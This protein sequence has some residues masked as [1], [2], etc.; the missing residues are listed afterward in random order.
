[1]NE[2]IMLISAYAIVVVAFLVT[3]GFAEH[4]QK[5]MPCTAVQV[6]IKDTMGHNFVEEQ[7][8]MELVNNKFGNLKGKPLSSINISLLEKIINTNP[9]IA[10]A[11]VFSTIDG[12]INIEVKQRTPIVRIVNQKVITQQ[13]LQLQMDI[14]S[15]RNLKEELQYT[16][17]KREILQLNFQGSMKYFM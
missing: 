4:G 9:F 3:L 16:T 5:S 14:F 1:M 13:E 7:E 11:E 15:I 2:R 17:G 12:K 8:I 6:V 10:D